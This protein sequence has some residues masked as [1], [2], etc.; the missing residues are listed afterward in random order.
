MSLAFLYAGQG[1]QHPGMGADLYEAHPAFRAVLD[2]AGVD[3]D[4]KTTMFTDPDGV[5]NLTEYTQ[6]CMVAFAAGMTALLAERGIVPDYAAGLSLGEYSALQCA[7]VFTAP[8]AISLAAFRGK[9]MAAAAAGRPCGMT[10]VLCLDREKLQEACRQAAGA[11]VVEIANYNCPGQLVI[12]GEQAAVDKA[13]AL[14]KELGAKRC[15]PLKVSGPFHTSLLAPAGDALREKFKE[16]AFGAMRIPVLFNC[17]GR[18][19]GP[20]DTIPALL[21][22][23]VQTSVY[24]EDTIRR[25]AELGV[26]TIVEIGPG[27][28][29]SGFVK[30][31]APAIKTY[32]VETCA[33][34][35]ALSA[36]LKG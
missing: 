31:T 30:K 6:P 9:A 19:M 27:K 23:Q 13:A 14:A 12:G 11:G 29:L 10:A 21:E 8:Q 2:A 5:L 24:M 16:T 22:K 1:S 20:E 33:D 35:D 3:F 25:L 17:L 18:E 34:L 4:L 26:D 7:G 32:A 36:A 15:L 28:A